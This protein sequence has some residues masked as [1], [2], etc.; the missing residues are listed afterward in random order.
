[1]MIFKALSFASSVIPD[2]VSVCSPSSAFS[3]ISKLPNGFFVLVE[4]LHCQN[5]G[6]QVS[7][8]FSSRQMPDH[9]FSCQNLGAQ[10]EGPLPQVTCAP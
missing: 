5:F 9:P 2:G 3:K 10:N 8:H 7:W 6:A 1:M 4:L